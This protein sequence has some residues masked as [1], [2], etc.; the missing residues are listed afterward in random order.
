M[1]KCLFM[2]KKLTQELGVKVLSTFFGIFSVEQGAGKKKWGVPLVR[3]NG[4]D[5]YDIYQ[6]RGEKK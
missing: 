6:T 2:R 4:K 1:F 3:Q 5:Y